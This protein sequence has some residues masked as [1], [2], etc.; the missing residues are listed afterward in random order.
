LFYFICSNALNELLLRKDLCNW[1]TGVNIRYNLSQLEKWIRDNHM[2]DM[3]IR[4]AI[5]PM[6]EASLLLQARWTDRGVAVICDIC[7]QLSLTQVRPC[8]LCNKSET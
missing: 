7:T 3:G 2:T 5:E 4:Q 6:F 8:V 1:S